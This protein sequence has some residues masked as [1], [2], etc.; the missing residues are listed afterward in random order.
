VLR[1]RCTIALA[2]QL[3]LSSS[4]SFERIADFLL[5]LRRAYCKVNGVIR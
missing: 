5:W 1:L 3:S 2:G 4:V